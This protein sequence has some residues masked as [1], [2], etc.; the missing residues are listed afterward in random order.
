MNRKNNR[1]VDDE[2]EDIEVDGVDDIPTR[3]T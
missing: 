3:L 2:D 1:I